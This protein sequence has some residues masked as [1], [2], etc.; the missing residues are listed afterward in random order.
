M[1]RKPR[2]PR[3]N[4]NN[5]K[6]TETDRNRQKPTGDFVFLVFLVFLV[7]L[8]G[9]LARRS[10][11]RVSVHSTLHRGENPP[12]GRGC[13]LCSNSIHLY[14]FHYHRRE[15]TRNKNR[16]SSL[17]DGARGTCT[18]FSESGRGLLYRRSTATGRNSQVASDLT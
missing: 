13:E 14:L 8:H 2:K 6:T 11:A 5:N 18:P 7:L 1:P 10:Q 12:R 3:N 9:A 17:D 15:I 16:L 4:I